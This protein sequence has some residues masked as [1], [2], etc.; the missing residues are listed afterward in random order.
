MSASRRD[1][2]VQRIAALRTRLQ[3]LKSE[4]KSPMLDNTET[5][6]E[7][8]RRECQ[9]LLS[10]AE[11]LLAHT[12]ETTT[13][14]LSAENEQRKE[15]AQTMDLLR[16]ENAQLK[17]MLEKARQ[18][19]A[20]RKELLEKSKKEIESLKASLADQT[21][22]TKSL[23]S[24]L[25]HQ[26]GASASPSSASPSTSSQSTTTT[27]TTTPPTTVA[28]DLQRSL[29]TS[30]PAAASPLTLSTSA[31]GAA[32]ATSSASPSTTLVSSSGSDDPS[33]SVSLSL[34]KLINESDSR[35]R[36]ETLCGDEPVPDV[37]VSN[38]VSALPVSLPSSAAASTSKQE[39]PG[40]SQF[41]PA[42]VC[43]LAH[44]LPH[45]LTP[46][47]ATFLTG[48]IRSIATS[49]TIRSSSRCCSD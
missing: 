39:Q 33:S 4:V 12:E 25:Q 43:S 14:A 20:L 48:C 24:Q 2:E 31:G 22:L 46:S 45:S 19:E 6:L 34:E 10:D 16:K 40:R 1:E 17:G 47:L 37:V 44:S 38:I 11:V 29:S 23:E 5:R 30:A 28:E 7:E 8:V 32:T 3:T 27:T 15:I 41:T 26:Q 21:A 42:L 18:I 36:R 35:V 13:A 9:G 49:Q